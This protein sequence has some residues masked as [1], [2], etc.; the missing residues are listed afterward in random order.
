MVARSANIVPTKRAIQ[1]RQKTEFILPV[2][3]EVARVDRARRL[4]KAP[5]NRGWPSPEYRDR[6][7]GTEL[8]WILFGRY[9]R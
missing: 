4:G 2:E 5:L 9:A 6:S 8:I 3:G 1:L 7:N